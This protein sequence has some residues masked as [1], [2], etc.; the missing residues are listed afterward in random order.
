M[1]PRINRK[2][3]RAPLLDAG[4][5]VLDILAPVAERQRMLWRLLGGDAMHVLAYGGG[6][7]G[8]T[9]TIMKAIVTRALGAPGSTHAVL[10]FRFNH[11]KASII[12]D[13]LPTVMKNEFPDVPWTLNKSDWYVDL[14]ASVD[15]DG[16]TIYSR[17]YFG[18]LDDAVRTEKIL[19]QGH[20]TI[21]LNECSQ[22]SYGARNKAVTRLSQKVPLKND[23]TKFLRLRA[24]YDENPPLQGHWTHK[25][26]IKKQ[27]PST[28][29]PLR[30]PED[31]DALQVNPKDNPHIPEETLKILD[32]LPAKERERFYAGNF[33]AAIDSALWTYEQVEACHCPAD[34][35]FPQ[36]SQVVVA[37]DPSGCRGEEDERSD[38]VGIVA[39]ALGVDGVVYVLQDAS[40][41]YGPGGVNGWGAKACEL[42]YKWKADSIVGE[43]NFGGA[44]V[45]N[46]IFTTDPNVPFREVVATRGKVVRAEP[47]STLY[48]RG[49][50]RHL[51]P[52]PELEE[53]MVNFSTAGYQGEKSPDRADAM[54][55]GVTT[56]A[57]SMIPGAGLLDW[58]EQQARAALA[59]KAE[60]PPVEI[61]WK[62][63]SDGTS[64]TPDNLMVSL[65]RPAGGGSVIYGMLGTRYVVDQDGH[66]RVSPE[67][68][69]PLM[70]SGFSKERLLA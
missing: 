50:V 61:G 13:T 49:L 5:K 31:Y 4:P 41:R 62:F 7:S 35:R 17:I 20:S 60:T 64:D 47:V 40:G 16:Q 3:A 15:K 42:Y 30:N 14:P 32:M 55:W 6:R 9:Y 1:A 54:V 58:Y 28:G 46:T 38:E 44:M 37:V 68:V 23:P 59:A 43:R 36:F 66:V 56:V 57:V 11:L 53:Q 10:R 21:Y 63:S 22:I 69:G 65:W 45:M 52:F 27:E 39:V 24:Y 33:Q 12:F 29:Q 70:Q 67:D 2:V 8:K 18:G 19:G 26:F 34:F 48:G 25:L 51:E